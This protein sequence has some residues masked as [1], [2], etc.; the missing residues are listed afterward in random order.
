[1]L[2]KLFLLLSLIAI[3]AC[4][5]DADGECENNHS[6]CESDVL[7][8]CDDG[9]WILFYNCAN[10]QLQCQED[11]TTNTALCVSGITED[12]RLDSAFL[13]P[14]Y[15][16]YFTLRQTGL[17]FDYNADEADSIAISSESKLKLSAFSMEGE[18]GIYMLY[19]GSTLLFQT[20]GYEFMSDATLLFQT[21]RYDFMKTDEVNSTARVQ[22]V[23]ALG[24]FNPDLI[25]A[26]IGDGV[27]EVDFGIRTFIQEVYIDV[28]YDPSSG[29]IIEQNTRRSCIIGISATEEIEAGGE[30]FEIAVG[31]IYGCFGANQ[32]GALGETLKMMFNLEMSVEEDDLLAFINERKDYTVAQFG[33][34][35]YDPNL[36]TCYALYEKDAAGDPLEIDCADFDVNEPLFPADAN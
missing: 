4:T 21:K 16:N 26:M 12:C 35:D 7:L 30:K 18:W 14:I 6:K 15:N 3:I 34:D 1:M 23:S 36:C 31:K 28:K 20:K 33:D 10:D 32:V 17:V 13:E 8:L 9:V 24:Q 2:Q 27:K 19:S 29:A 11:N 22:L 25:P 5:P